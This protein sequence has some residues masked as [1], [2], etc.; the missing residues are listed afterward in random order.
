MPRP[1]VEAGGI[2]GAGERRILDLLRNHS[3]AFPIRV[4]E[5]PA[6]SGSPAQHGA[7]RESRALCVAGGARWCDTAMAGPP[8][9][10]VPAPAE[11]NSLR[12]RAELPITARELSGIETAA[13]SGVTSAA[14]A[15][16]TMMRL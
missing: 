14:I 12:I 10:P 11:R 15:S 2:P 5:G 4:T 3:C 16:G 8:H 1:A 7:N 6:F 9:R 13:T